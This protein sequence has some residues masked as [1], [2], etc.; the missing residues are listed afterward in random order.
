MDNHQEKQYEQYLQ[1]AIELGK[2]ASEIIRA[3][4]IQ[5]NA[6]ST[7]GGAG[8]NTKSSPLD[9]L[10]ETD[11]AV[12]HFIKSAI[13]ERYPGHSLYVWPDVETETDV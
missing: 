8:V 3:G 5:R 2:K 9:F 10:T 4:Q 1:F 13:A 11:L 7:T 12:E 6:T